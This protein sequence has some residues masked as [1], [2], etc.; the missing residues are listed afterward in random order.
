MT[1]IAETK[2]PAPSK[3]IRTLSVKLKGSAASQS[4]IGLKAPNIM[5]RASHESNKEKK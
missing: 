3:K 4:S 1:K 5:D 2:H